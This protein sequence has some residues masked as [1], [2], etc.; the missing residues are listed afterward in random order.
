MHRIPNSYSNSKM[1]HLTFF[2]YTYFM[3]FL[4][5]INS[6]LASYYTVPFQR[7]ARSGQHSTALVSSIHLCNRGASIPHR[8]NYYPSCASL[9]DLIFFNSHFT[10]LICLQNW[11]LLPRCT[12]TSSQAHKVDQCN[13]FAL[14]KIFYQHLFYTITNGSTV[15]IGTRS[16]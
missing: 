1:N 13:W 14:S 8:P 4:L 6:R 7:T 12:P 10:R 5:P 16:F 11:S 15:T 3:F 9:V 2:L